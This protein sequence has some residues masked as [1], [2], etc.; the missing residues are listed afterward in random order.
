MY[1]HPKVLRHYLAGVQWAIG[2]LKAE[3]GEG[4]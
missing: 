3:L 1:W 4:K 2:D